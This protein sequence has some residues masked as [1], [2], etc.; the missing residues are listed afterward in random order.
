MRKTLKELIAE[1]DKNG[2]A[3]GSPIQLSEA[4]SELLGNAYYLDPSRPLWK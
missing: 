4:E 3:I 2:F 1:A